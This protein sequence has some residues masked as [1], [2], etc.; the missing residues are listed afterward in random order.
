ME[1]EK[2][3]DLIFLKIIVMRQLIRTELYREAS[4][5]QTHISKEKENNCSV[6]HQV[7]PSYKMRCLSIYHRKLL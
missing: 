1:F 6:S 5:I 7:Q 4:M 2:A 3:N